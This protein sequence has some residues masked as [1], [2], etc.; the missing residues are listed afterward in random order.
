MC[1]VWEQG[2]GRHTYDE[3]IAIGL[4]GLQALAALLGA[5]PFGETISSVDATGFALAHTLARHP[6]SQRV[7]DFV[8]EHPDLMAYHARIWQRFWSTGAS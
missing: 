7:Q 5:Q 2:I 1:Q 6:F 3:V 8:L 4:N